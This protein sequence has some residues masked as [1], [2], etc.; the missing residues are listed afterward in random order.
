MIK[1]NKIKHQNTLMETVAIKRNQKRVRDS[2]SRMGVADC[3][4]HSEVAD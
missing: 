3:E 4:H 1:N 2:G